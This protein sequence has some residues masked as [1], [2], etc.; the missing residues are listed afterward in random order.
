MEQEMHVKGRE[1]MGLSAK[2][3][4]TRCVDPIPSK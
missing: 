1:M 3:K 2:E 4:K